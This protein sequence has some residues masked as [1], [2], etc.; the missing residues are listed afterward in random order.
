MAAAF[1]V[2]RFAGGLAGESD[3]ALS[4][5]A[6]KSLASGK[7]ND[8]S[9]AIAELAEN[10]S[11]R[12]REILQALLAGRLYHDRSGG[13]L[14]ASG[15]DDS[16][17]A[18]IAGGGAFAGD[19]GTLKKVVINNGQRREIT[20]VLNAFAL[21]GGTA[22]DRRAASLAL[23]S[24]AAPDLDS[25][26]LG[27]LLG[28][29]T[30]PGVRRNLEAALG[31]ALARNGASSQADL[32]SAVE[33][34]SRGGQA[35]TLSALASLAASPNPLVAK[36]AAD[37]LYWIRVARDWAGFTETLFFG[38]SLGS[39]LVLAAIGLAITFGVMGVINMAHGELIMI[40]AYVVWGLQRLLP[41][42]TALAMIISIPAAFI[43]SG[44]L[45]LVLE[46]CVIRFLYGRPLETLLATFGISLILQQAVRTLISSQNRAVDNPAFL[47][48]MWRITENFS[49]TRNRFYIL[50]FC[51]AV[52][53]AIYAVMHWTRLGVEV[54][55]V[56]Q[57]RPIARAMGV[58]DSRVDALTFGLGSGVA[59]LAG[60]ALSQITNVGPNLGQAY[61]ID[62]FMV[63]VFGGVGNLWGTLT[64]GLILGVANKALEPL[65]G[66]ML[67]KIFIL[68][69]I[70]LFIQ[71]RPRGLFPQRGRAAEG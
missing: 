42:Q 29:E 51:L 66:A 38:L 30:D 18:D 25:E 37:S 49:V 55:A 65:S 35:V 3:S 48:G 5:A 63:V 41:G 33:Y 40:G 10:A 61:I 2:F 60:V 67:A 27:R 28:N 23:L 9:L 46:L 47:S 44:A 57:N 13:G 16:A 70:I 8:R 1:L 56:S 43:V 32:E 36:K 6:I 26:T 54:R 24:E 64:G 34:L 53:G 59:G 31:L 4:G 12:A 71:K 68:V 11:P 45:G 17:P 21:T 14:Y 50:L 22:E 69:S 19:R 52:F 62:S 15:S 58:R 39:I 7:V 20:R